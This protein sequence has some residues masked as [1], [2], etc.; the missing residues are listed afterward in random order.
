MFRKSWILIQNGCTGYRFTQDDTKPWKHFT[1]KTSLQISR[2]IELVREFFWITTRNIH[3]KWFH[4]VRVMNSSLHFRYFHDS[5]QWVVRNTI[6]R[7]LH[8]FSGK[9]VSN[10]VSSGGHRFVHSRNQHDGSDFPHGSR[11][12][13]FTHR[14]QHSQYSIAWITGWSGHR[15][16]VHIVAMFSRILRSEKSE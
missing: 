2:I 4:S 8:D 3:P 6:E 7:L 1:E 10:T 12:G 15:K 16:L 5:G 13:I 14:V 9:M 11:G